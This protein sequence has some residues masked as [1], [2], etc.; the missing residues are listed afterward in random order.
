MEAINIHPEELQSANSESNVKKYD[1]VYSFF[2]SDSKVGVTMIITSLAELLAE[3]NKV[4]VI[5]A[6]RKSGLD[7]CGIIDNY[8]GI[9]ELQ[10]KLY[11]NILEYE[12]LRKMII[13][14]KKIDI[15]P[16]VKELE[17]CRYFRVEDI[18]SILDLVYDKYDLILIDAGSDFEYNAL[19][20]GSLSCTN[21]TVL[22]TTQQET[23]IRE[24]KRV[25][26]LS[27]RMDIK[28]NNLLINKTQPKGVGVMDVKDIQ[29]ITN[30]ETIM[31]EVPIS[32][33]SWQVESDHTSLSKE[34]S[35]FKL[36][37]LCTSDVIADK[38][39]IQRSLSSSK[40]RSFLGFLGDKRGK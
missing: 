5:N 11:S 17:R 24:M 22:V 37:M 28:F 32:P 25:L 8:L 29:N 18:Y 1:N 40:P 9:D 14:Y 10:N 4:L 38:L 26:F 20:I 7:Y 21:N 39:N 16:G 27:E 31:G 30:I 35:E 6:N 3:Y 2:G 23:V 12:D 19:A 15:I 33:Y 36:E 13:N 34:D